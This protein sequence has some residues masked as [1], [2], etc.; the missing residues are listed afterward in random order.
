MGQESARQGCRDPQFFTIV[1]TRYTSQTVF[2]FDLCTYCKNSTRYD[3]SH[4][5]FTEYTMTGEHGQVGQVVVGKQQ[6]QQP[7]VTHQSP[8]AQKQDHEPVPVAVAVPGNSRRKIP[9]SQDEIAQWLR[10]V[11]LGQLVDKF[12]TEQVNDAKSLGALVHLSIADLKSVLDISSGAMVAR[13][14][15]ELDKLE[16]A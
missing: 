1:G 16:G 8:Q 5:P 14:K 4:G 2:N 6:Q 13:L 11:D 12:V 3:V 10:D 15:A 9:N 7:A